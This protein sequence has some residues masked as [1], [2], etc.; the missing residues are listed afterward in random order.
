MSGGAWERVSAYVNNG[1]SNLSGSI[2]SA[3][4]KYKNMYTVGATDDQPSNYALTV[5]FKG[6]AIY[7]TSSTQ[8]GST[9]WFTDLSNMPV[10]S[11]M[12]FFRGGSWAEGTTAGTYNFR[13]TH[14]AAFSNIGFRP[15][16]AVSVGL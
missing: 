4:G 14:G 8:T 15:V 9:S 10:F 5:N 2:V 11:S 3:D 12:W 1:N 13:Y 16:L 7:E 6:D